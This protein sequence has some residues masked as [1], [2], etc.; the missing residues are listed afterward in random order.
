MVQGLDYAGDVS[1]QVAY[2][3]LTTDPKSRLIDVRTQ[4]EWAFVGQVDPRDF[5]GAAIGLSWQVYPHMAVNAEFAETLK[6]ELLQSG[7]TLSDPLFFLCK[8]GAR[9]L[10][11]AREMAAH[12]FAACY[13]IAGGFE[14]DHDENGHRGNRNGWKAA[15]LAWRQN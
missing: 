7:V 4:P 9:S 5:S 2:K 1:P 14:G 12:G 15:G 13:N 6:N 11:A 10:A 8:S 3:T